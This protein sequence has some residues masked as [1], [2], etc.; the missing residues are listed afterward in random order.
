MTLSLPATVV[1]GEGA[2]KE[3]GMKLPSI[4]KQLTVVVYYCA[5]GLLYMKGPFFLSKIIN[6]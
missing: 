3:G 5:D 1:K 2:T 6:K 4:L